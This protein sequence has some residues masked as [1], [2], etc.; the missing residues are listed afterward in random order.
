MYNFDNFSVAIKMLM[1]GTQQYTCCVMAVAGNPRIFGITSRNFLQNTRNLYGRFHQIFLAT[2]SSVWKIT[3][4]TL[5]QK[6]NH[7]MKL[8][9]VVL[10][11]C[12]TFILGVSWTQCIGQHIETMICTSVKNY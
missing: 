10:L 7:W 8:P 4:I 12:I 5:F 3:L 9:Y 2:K 1:R 6:A 11:G